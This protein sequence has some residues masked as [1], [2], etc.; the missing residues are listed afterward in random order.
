MK[1]K[2]G[3]AIAFDKQLLRKIIIMSKLCILLLTCT[4]FTLQAGPTYAQQVKIKLEMKNASLIDII[5]AIKQ[6]TEFE[7]AYDSNLE[8]VKLDNISINAQNEKIDNVLS[9]ILEGTD[10]NYKIIDK[11]I[12]LSKNTLKT[13]STHENR[14]DIQQLKITGTVTDEKGHPLPGVTILVKGTT[15]GALTDE[16]GKYTITNPPKNA[17]LVFSFIGMATQEIPSNDQDQIDIV[18]KETAIGLDDVIVVGYGTQKKVNLTGSVSSVKGDIITK[19]P[20]SNI[21]NALIG[22]LP[23]VRAIQSSGEPGQDASSIDIRGF[24]GALIIV[25]GIAAD[26]SQIDPSEIESISI[27]KDGSAA[28]YGVRAANGVV[29]VTTKKGTLTKPEITFNSYY[30]VQSLTRFPSYVNAA[31]YVELSDEAAINDGRAPIFGK[32][33]VQKYRN[34]EAGYEGTDWYDLMVRKY[35]PQMYS[36]LT[37]S[38]GTDATKY[39]F[40]LGYFDQEGMWKSDDQKFKRYNFRSN[41]SSKIGKRLTAEFNLSGR[42][43]NLDAPSNDTYTLMGEMHRMY[44]TEPAYTNNNPLYLAST[45]ININALALMNKDIVGYI[46]DKYRYISGIVS[47][48][49]ELPFI[50][51]LNAKAM[52]SYQSGTSNRK[53]WKKKYNLYTYD[54]ATSSYPVSFTGNDPS[55]LTLTNDQL[56]EQ[57][58]QLSLDYNT[59]INEKHKIKALLLFER[60]EG[61]DSKFSA[62]R[63]FVLDALDQMFAGSSTNKNNDGSSSENANMGY[64]GRL[65]YDY[66]NKYLLEA[67]FRYD[68]SY[69]F[70]KASRFGFFPTFS[71]GWRISNESFLIDNK[72]ISNMKLRASWGKM[73]DDGSATPFSWITGYNFP[74]GSYIFGDN[75]TQG[76]QS[77]GVP[78]NKLTWY[79][80]TTTNLGLEIGILKNALTFEF[81]VFRRD[82]T[83]LLATRTLTLP[84]TYGATIPQENLNSDN[85]RGFELVVGYNNKIGDFHYKISANTSWTRSRSNYIEQASPT[86]AYEN[87]RNNG[88]DRWNNIYWGYKAAGQ[89]QSKDE[90]S[91][92]AIQDQN[93]NTTLLPGDIKYVDLNKDGIIDDKDVTVIG[94]GE[95]PELFYGLTLSADYKGFDFSMLFQGASDFNYYSPGWYTQNSATYARFMDRWHKEDMYDPNSA[96]VPGKYP[97]TRPGNGIPNNK[98]TSSFWLED[99]TYLR[100]KTL[101]IGYSIPKTL[102]SIKGVEQIHFY[103]SGQNLLTFCKL[104]DVDPEAPVD[105]PHY[106]PQQRVMTLGINAKF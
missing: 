73:G 93:A 64:V 70:P 96:W 66:N 86:N 54:A 58:L 55:N 3:K 67:G 84:G 56:D 1:K 2:C 35:N 22:N 103:F 97:S 74:V 105:N 62:Y 15:L 47:L 68:G 31:Q 6:Q 26:F 52:Y 88:S 82:R 83:G 49:Y 59:T 10:I 102:F 41:I 16:S 38:G 78:N 53:T 95:I 77:T 4:V 14:L 28:I 48:N 104:K 40:S 106:Y 65:N 72:V 57:T 37:A 99:A 75:I 46:N 9:S 21:T 39:F 60:S 91:S 51:G 43:E 71:A 30:G 76:L 80:S 19:S 33:K 32:E 92:W 100:I 101:E 90:I 89:F 8:L 20:V 11:I 13:T 12:L 25:D 45:D 5:S 63:E 85:T 29:L 81:D 94:R 34:R 18:L 79:T 87:W 27:L 61:L 7:F 24:G 42:L 98:Y 69:L 23:G 44:P 36:N 50:N 17:T